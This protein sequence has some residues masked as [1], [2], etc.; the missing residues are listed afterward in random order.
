MNAYLRFSLVCWAAPKGTSLRCL[1]GTQH[2][3]HQ[4]HQHGWDQ[5]AGEMQ[6]SA[7]S[8]ATVTVTVTV[9]P[10]GASECYGPAVVQQLGKMH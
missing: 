7:G 5:P 1:Q 4:R 9:T 8:P 2:P 10:C 3:Q 6:L